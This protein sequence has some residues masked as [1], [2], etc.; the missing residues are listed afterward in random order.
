M[1]SPPGNALFRRNIR[2]GH[3]EQAPD[4]EPELIP[5]GTLEPTTASWDVEPVE[6]EPQL[7]RHRLVP[8]RQGRWRVTLPP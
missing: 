7:D 1:V 8:F 6:N 3:R 4:A 5:S 2:P